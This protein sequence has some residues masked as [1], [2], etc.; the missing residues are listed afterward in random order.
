MES[1]SAVESSG[2]HPASRRSHVRARLRTYAVASTDADARSCVPCVFSLF[3]PLSLSLSL[4][5]ALALSV[6]ANSDLGLD[7]GV[8]VASGNGVG[9]EGRK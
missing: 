9:Y 8:S 3:L 4:S 7:E 6:A 2:R 5:L 1:A